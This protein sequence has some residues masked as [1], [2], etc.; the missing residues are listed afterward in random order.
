MHAV[1]AMVLA[2]LDHPSRPTRDVSLLRT[3]MSG[4]SNVPFQSDSFSLGTDAGDSNSSNFS[5]EQGV[6]A[7]CAQTLYT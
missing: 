6:G 1:P 4:G 2:M 7:D 5:D 3:M